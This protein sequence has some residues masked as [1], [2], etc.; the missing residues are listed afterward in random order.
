[1]RVDEVKAAQHGIAVSDVT[2]ALALALSGAQVGLI[3]DQDARE[4]VPA[5]VELTA[6]TVPPSRGWR[7]S[8]CPARTAA[9]FRCASW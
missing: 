9:W 2:H 1:M 4:P 6:R 7:I 3:H 8:A 5:M